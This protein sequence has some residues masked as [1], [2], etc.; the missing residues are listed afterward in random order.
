MKIEKQTFYVFNN[1]TDFFKYIGFVDVSQYN[2]SIEKLIEC[3][4]L[5]TKKGQI[6]FSCDS[7]FNWCVLC[8]SCSISCKKTCSFLN[9][10]YKKVYVSR[11]SKL[12]RILK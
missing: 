5:D 11:K 1:P 7:H 2:F 10:E 9:R 12:D 6:W 8:D 4:N 3:Y